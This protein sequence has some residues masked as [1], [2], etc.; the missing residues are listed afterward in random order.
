[1]AEAA[2][3][4]ADTHGTDRASTLF[5]QDELEQAVSKLKTVQNEM[6]KLQYDTAQLGKKLKSARNDM[7]QAQK[8]CQVGCAK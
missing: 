5:T 8:E 1:M 7:Y 6:D 3:A 4:L 2:A